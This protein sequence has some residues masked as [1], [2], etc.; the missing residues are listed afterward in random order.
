MYPLTVF[1]KPIHPDGRKAMP[2][3]RFK[4]RVYKQGDFFLIAMI[5]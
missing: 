2:D 3:V 1:E 5:N 4:I